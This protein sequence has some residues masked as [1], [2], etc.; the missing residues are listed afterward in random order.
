[1]PYASIADHNPHAPTP[2]RKAMQPASQPQHV[3]LSEDGNR[4]GGCRGERKQRC[5]RPLV[6]GR[7]AV[8]NNWLD[9]RCGRVRGGGSPLPS[10]RGGRCRKGRVRR[11]QAIGSGVAFRDVPGTIADQGARFALRAPPTVASLAEEEV[12]LASQSSPTFQP[13]PLSRRKGGA[14]LGRRSRLPQG[15]ALEPYRHIQ[16]NAILSKACILQK[17]YLHLIAA[18][19]GSRGAPIS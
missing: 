13:L 15:Y 14:S 12:S 19:I 11:Y 3:R 4:L 9:R 7:P 18:L 10:V 1:M 8:E 5:S 16:T 6:P 17:C 2:A